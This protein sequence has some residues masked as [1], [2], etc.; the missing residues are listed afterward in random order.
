MYMSL[1]VITVHVPMSKDYIQF[2]ED[3][4]EK[5]RN[6]FNTSFNKNDVNIILAGFHDSVLLYGNAL[7]E[8]LMHGNNPLDG[9][10]I[11]RLLWNRSFSGKALP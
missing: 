9:F 1:M 2:T 8:T 3:V 10:S 5:S 11:T 6:E 4:I 7:T